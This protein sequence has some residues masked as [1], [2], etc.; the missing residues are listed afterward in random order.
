V[1]LYTLG[2]FLL[3]TMVGIWCL[4]T[5][6]HLSQRVCIIHCMQLENNTVQW[7]LLTC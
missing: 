4:S 2:T 1:D 7:V 5:Y 3:M 6:L